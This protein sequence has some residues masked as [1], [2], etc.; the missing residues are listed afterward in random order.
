MELLSSVA[1]ALELKR[2]PHLVRPIKSLTLTFCD[3][4]DYN[5]CERASG[6]WMESCNI[7]DVSPSVISAF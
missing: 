2:C 6:L 3:T 1:S 4:A 5:G 7:K